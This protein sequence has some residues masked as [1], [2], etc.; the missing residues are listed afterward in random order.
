MD[1]LEIVETLKEDI[2]ELKT[3]LKKTKEI[4]NKLINK[5][6]NMYF[7]YSSDNN[8]DSDDNCGC[9]KMPQKECKEIK[10]YL[11]NYLLQ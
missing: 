4:V 1:T 3:E 10:E 7:V 6:N 2:K 5:I 8:S 11:D 9:Y